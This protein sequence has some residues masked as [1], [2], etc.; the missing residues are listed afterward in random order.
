MRTPCY[1]VKLQSMFS[2][3]EKCYKAIAFDGSEALI[4]TSQVYGK[5]PDN[6]REDV[7]AWWISKWILE[8]KPIQHSTKRHAFFDS[9]TRKRLADGPLT[10]YQVH[11]PQPIKAIESKANESLTR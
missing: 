2:I 7:E 5:D 8:Q 11:V 4:P 10:T 9:E 1:S 6:S 3:S